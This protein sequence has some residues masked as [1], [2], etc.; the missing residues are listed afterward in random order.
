VFRAKPP[1]ETIPKQAALHAT[2][3]RYSPASS[4]N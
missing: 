1:R 4:C 2:L 3:R